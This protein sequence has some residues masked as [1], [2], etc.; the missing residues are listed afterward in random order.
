M[1][2]FRVFCVFKIELGGALLDVP[3][4]LLVGAFA[5]LLLLLLLILL[6]SL[7]LWGGKEL[8]SLKEGSAAEKLRLLVLWL[9][10]ILLLVIVGLWLQLTLP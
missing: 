7:L 5:L 2:T 1:T 4:G 3:L 8:I 6:L 9:L 10:E